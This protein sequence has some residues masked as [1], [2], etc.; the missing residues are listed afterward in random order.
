[1]LVS[2]V[3]ALAALPL[4]LFVIAWR[5]T[6]SRLA[7]G[8]AV[9]FG[10]LGWYMPAHV[11]NWGKYPALFGVPVVLFTVAAAYLS[12]V[13]ADAGH[14]RRGLQVLAAVGACVAVLIHTRSLILLGILLMA[15]LF[16]GLWLGRPPIQRRLAIGVVVAGLVMEVLM[17]VRIPVLAP[18][19]DPYLGAGI[20]ITALAG[21]LGVFAFKSYPRFAFA[22]VLALALLCLGLFI[23]VPGFS[24][25][26]LL[27]RPLVEMVLFVP[28]ALLGA[29][30]F[31][32]LATMIP[33]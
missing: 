26:P 33:A 4:P 30:G 13:G 3:I 2:G 10:S 20:W 8:L 29:A 1:M 7:G 24:S 25:G 17:L 32:A 27:D 31:A 12:N 21:L 14:G 15:W 28:L 11:L 23:P 22:T 19:L 6:G 5:E 9:V 18:L 16:S